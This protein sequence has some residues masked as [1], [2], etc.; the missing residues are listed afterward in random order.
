M[1]GGV[2]GLWKRRRCRLLG[3]G[4]EPI[5]FEEVIQSDAGDA[6]G[7]GLINKVNQV[8]AG[9]VGILREE[10]SDGS[11]KAR[12]ELSVGSSI[13]PMMSLLDDDFGGEPLLS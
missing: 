1:L 9:S 3:K 4:I 5:L 7:E 11:S 6:D 2:N 12:Q 10:L 8:S 13:E